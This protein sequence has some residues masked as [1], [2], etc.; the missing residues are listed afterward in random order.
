MW[1]KSIPTFKYSNECI[2][3]NIWNCFNL[4]C[5][6]WCHIPG[7]VSQHAAGLVS[8]LIFVKS[9]IIS[10]C[11]T[12]TR[13]WITFKLMKCGKR[14]KISSHEKMAQNQNPFQLLR[15]P[16]LYLNVKSKFSPIVTKQNNQG[17]KKVPCSFLKAIHVNYHIFKEILFCLKKME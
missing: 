3:V 12:L 13:W 1:F 8:V 7:S 9:L 16:C 17:R 5:G 2:S 6:N 10:N 11:F 4:E 14:E 15:R